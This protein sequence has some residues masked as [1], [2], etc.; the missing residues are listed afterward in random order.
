MVGDIEELDFMSADFAFTFTRSPTYYR[1]SD[2]DCTR[3]DRLSYLFYQNDA[4]WWVLASVNG[5]EDPLNDLVAGTVLT[6]P[7]LLDIYDFFKAQRKR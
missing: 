5:I 2:N 7:D 6:V 4:Y 1:V 3:L